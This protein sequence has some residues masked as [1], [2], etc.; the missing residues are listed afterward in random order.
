MILFGTLV[1]MIV[2]QHLFGAASMI[3]GG[4]G[5]MEA[6][7]FFQL[8]ERGVSEGIAM[9]LAITIRLVTLWFDMLIGVVSLLFLSAQDLRSKRES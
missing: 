7:L 5:A 2:G 4:L 6:A 9:S 1:A 3:P 8:V